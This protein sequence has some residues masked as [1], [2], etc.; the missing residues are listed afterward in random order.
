MN[1]ALIA[2]GFVIGALT[3]LTGVG[4]AALT[5]PFLIL[6]AGVAP[7]R[8]VGTDFV[9]S[10]ATKLLGTH[11]HWKQ[12]TVDRRVVLRLA[13]ASVPGLLV[14]T[15]LLHSLGHS[16]S[17]DR[18]LT[19]IIG[20][21]ILL[22]GAALGLQCFRPSQTDEWRRRRSWRWRHVLPVAFVL[23][24][25]VGITSVGSGSLFFVL[26]SLAVAIPVPCVVGSDVAHAAL[27]TGAGALISV[28]ART[29]DPLLTVNLLLGSLPGVWLGSSLTARLPR[30]A[31][32]GILAVVL[33][34]TGASYAL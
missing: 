25:L 21:A 20:V 15:L 28:G 34:A 30:R 12:G 22:A 14:G 33:L 19:R 7:I 24:V 10:A 32:S 9:F 11:R 18:I 4:A 27:L 16:H 1:P 5:T 8:A 6:F 17:S 23:G 29:A 31:L 2:A 26:L 13:S 3:G